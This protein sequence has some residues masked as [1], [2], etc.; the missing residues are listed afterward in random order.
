VKPVRGRV[1]GGQRKPVAMVRSIDGRSYPEPLNDEIDRIVHLA[2]NN[3]HG[4]RLMDWL[5]GITLRTV[6]P[7]EA[8]TEQLREMEGQ[9]RLVAMLM[10]R[11]KRALEA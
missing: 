5:Q 6:L 2:L 9:R 3:E 1:A 11:M 4:R 10:Q 7:V 8:S